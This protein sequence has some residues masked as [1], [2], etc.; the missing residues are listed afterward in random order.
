MAKRCCQQGDGSDGKKGKKGSELIKRFRRILT[1]QSRSL[2]FVAF[3]LSSMN[4]TRSSNQ[5]EEDLRR[6]RFA[7]RTSHMPYLPASTKAL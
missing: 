2:T 3:R 1:S 6:C 7:L 4:T 5:A